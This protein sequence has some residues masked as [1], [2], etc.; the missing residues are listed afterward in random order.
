MMNFIYWNCFLLALLSSHSL[1][2]P[3]NASDTRQRGAGNTG[4]NFSVQV[5][6][7]LMNS[8]DW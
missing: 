6:F 3:V 8:L 4:N 1:G 7:L 2:F 5:N